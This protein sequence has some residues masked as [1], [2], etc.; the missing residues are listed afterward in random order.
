MKAKTHWVWTDKAERESRGRRQAGTRI[1]DMWQP[2]APDFMSVDGLIV[3]EEEYDYDNGQ[4]DL[5][6]LI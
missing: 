3:E 6:E 1:D 2:E 4:V 5:F